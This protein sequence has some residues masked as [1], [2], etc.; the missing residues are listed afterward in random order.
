MSNRIMATI[1][2][3]QDRDASGSG[4]GTMSPEEIAQSVTQDIIDRF[5]E[6]NFDVD[7]LVRSLE[8]QGPYQ[9]VFIQEMEV[10]NNLI[11]EMLRSLKELLLGFA[12]E[13]TMS[14]AMDLLKNCL[15]LDR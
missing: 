6:K 12:G 5:G 11:E 14:D 8:E 1:L 7:D 2:D 4:E 9:N 13:L 15:Y 3:L 10:M